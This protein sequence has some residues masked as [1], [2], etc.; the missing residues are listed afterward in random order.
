MNRLERYRR[1]W[2]DNKNAD[3]R[4]KRIAREEGLA[5]GFAGGFAGGREQGREE[6]KAEIAKGLVQNGVPME[7]IT[8]VTGLTA[9]DLD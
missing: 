8:K 7:I 3:E 4:A 2:C 5:E 6:T 9:E 1:I